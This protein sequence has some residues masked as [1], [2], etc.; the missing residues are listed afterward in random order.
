MKCLSY[1]RREPAMT[2]SIPIGTLLNE[3]GGQME[4]M[5]K[6]SWRMQ[7]VHLILK[8]GQY[9][10][11][12][13]VSGR[14]DSMNPNHPPDESQE[15]PGRNQQLCWSR[16]AKNIPLQEPDYLPVGDKVFLVTVKKRSNIKV[17]F[18]ISGSFYLNTHLIMASNSPCWC[19]VFLRLGTKYQLKWNHKLI[20]WMQC[21]GTPS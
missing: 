5:S 1:G 21:S 14:M 16:E 10:K 15:A 2:H 12:W 6:L 11:L 18:D 9:E 20:K 7:S 17:V 13:K 8:G 3:S 4:R 19:S